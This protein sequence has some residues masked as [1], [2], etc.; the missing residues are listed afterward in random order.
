MSRDERI[1][2]SVLG[3]TIDV[4][5]RQAAA[6][7]ILGWALLR[8]SRSVFAA[9][10]H[11]V[12]SAR[13]D[14]GYG[15]IVNAADMVMPDGAPVAWLLRRQGHAQQVRISG[16]DLMWLLLERCAQA[17]V[18]VYL[19]GSTAATLA[20]LLSRASAAFPHLAIAGA[21]SPPFRP[22]TAA[23]DRAT[24]ERINASGAGVVFV[25]LGCPKQEQW[26]TAH[27][28]R[29]RAVMLGVGAA[30]DFHA[31]TVTRA[32]PW[33]RDHGLEWLHRLAAEPRRLW[34]RYLVTNTLFLFCA[35]A[36]LV[37]G[38]KTGRRI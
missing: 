12:V 1:T 10:V 8:E 38:G 6:D 29:V 13:R 28:G 26:I 36:Q 35:A 9:N 15:E 33:M 17:G 23:E 16:P 7:R 20:A 11:V 2:G 37:R 27:R 5:D 18:A 25:G 4:I 22:A 32:P 24:T 34:K 14:P 31:G 21:E 30:F 3:S 19:Y